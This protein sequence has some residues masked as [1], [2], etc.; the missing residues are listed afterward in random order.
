[1][2]L[3][4]CVTSGTEVKLAPVPGDIKAC[5]NRLVPKPKPGPMSRKDV[6]GL[7]GKLKKSELEKSLCG[8]RLID[9]YETQKGVF[10]R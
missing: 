8:K 2:T 9:W 10:E 4:G 5:F 1:M 7:I 6:V 3:S